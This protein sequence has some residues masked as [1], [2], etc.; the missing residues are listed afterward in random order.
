M[1]WTLER[2]V[3]N[4]RRCGVDKDEATRADLGRLR[5]AITATGIEFIENIAK[6]VHY[7]I[8]EA[9]DLAGLPDDFLAQFTPDADGKVMLPVSVVRSPGE[10]PDEPFPRR[11]SA[12]YSDR[13]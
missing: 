9:K 3:E 7:L 13:P 5:K 1:V 11:W 10:R 12:R 4:F 6:D 8:V 2:Q